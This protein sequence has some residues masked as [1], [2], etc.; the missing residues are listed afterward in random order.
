MTAASTCCK[1][2]MKSRTVT[3]HIMLSRERIDEIAY[4]AVQTRI[5][6]QDRLIGALAVPAQ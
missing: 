5:A 4:R 3:I 2:C 1:T 6:E